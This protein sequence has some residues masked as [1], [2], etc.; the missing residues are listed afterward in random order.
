MG[1]TAQQERDEW[2]EVSSGVI[3]IIIITKQVG[4]SQPYAVSV[5]TH[6]ICTYIGHS[7]GLPAVLKHI[8]Y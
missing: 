4:T 5:L 1:K 3:I 6:F 2:V 7:N 8:A